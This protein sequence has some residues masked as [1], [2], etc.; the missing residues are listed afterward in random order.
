MWRP[1]VFT[2]NPFILVI[3][4]HLPWKSWPAFLTCPL[5]RRYRQPA[6]AARTRNAG[7]WIQEWWESGS[8][9]GC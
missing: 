2:T 8:T 5:G 6:V 7:A 3:E 4:G 1:S 9:P